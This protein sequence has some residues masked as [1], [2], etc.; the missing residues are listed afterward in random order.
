MLGTPRPPGIGT[1]AVGPSACLSWPLGL[2]CNWPGPAALRVMPQWAP[3]SQGSQAT[4]WRPA[5]LCHFHVWGPGHVRDPASLGAASLSLLLG[6]GR[7]V[8]S[9][10]WWEARGRGGQCQREAPWH[11]LRW[12]CRPLP[13]GPPAQELHAALLTHY[14]QD[15]TWSQKSLGYL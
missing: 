2:P 9:S 11:E 12:Y 1:W 10:G 14:I 5:S 8:P 3:A 6:G 7:T 13:L 4:F 15:H